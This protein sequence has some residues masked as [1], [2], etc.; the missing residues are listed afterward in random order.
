MFNFDKAV[1]G[2]ALTREDQCRVLAAYVHRFTGNHVPAWARK[3][4]PDG[5]RYPLQFANDDDWLRHTLFVIRSDGRLD[6]RV[7]Q[8]H[9]RPT[10]PH[11]PE[12]RPFPVIAPASPDAFTTGR[13]GTLAPELAATE[14]TAKLNIE[15][16]RGSD[17]GKVSLFWRF[18]A[19]G[20]PCGIWDYRGARWSTDGP[21]EVFERLFPGMVRDFPALPPAGGRA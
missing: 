3:P 6:D 14:I 20:K 13:T 21:R 1:T 9:S 10:W 16:E 19:D 2:N 4:R 11:N 15:P 12:L 17:D 5:K 18:Y 8:C 7:R